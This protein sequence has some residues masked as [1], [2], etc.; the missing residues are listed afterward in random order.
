MYT[1]EHPVSLPGHTI[2]YYFSFDSFLSSCF[3]P[4][5][6]AVVERRH[7]SIYALIFFHSPFIHRSF[8]PLQKRIEIQVCVN[9]G[10]F[11]VFSSA[12]FS[13]C[14]FIVFFSHNRRNFRRKK[15]VSRVI[16]E[17][18]HQA[19]PSAVITMWWLIEVQK[20]KSMCL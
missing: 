14:S 16:V 6:F 19:F 8:I 20:T 1:V 2:V 15:Y 17:A 7:S 11:P 13:V 10:L 3:Y 4:F 18:I 5:I 12:C 9:H